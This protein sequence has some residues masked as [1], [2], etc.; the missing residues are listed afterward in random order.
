MTNTPI[1]K[2]AFRTVPREFSGNRAVLKLTGRKTCDVSIVKMEGDKFAINPKEVNCCCQACVDWVKLMTAV[3]NRG[4]KLWKHNNPADVKWLMESARK[5]T[6]MHGPQVECKKRGRPKSN[7][8]F[9]FTLT[10]S[11]ADGLSHTDMVVA[12][13]KVMAQKSQPVKTFAWYL[14]SKG[15]DASGTPIHPHIHGMYETVS[16]V[17]IKDQ[18]WKRAWKLWDP[19]VK[20]GAGFRGGYHR[21]VKSEEAYSEYIAKDGQLGEK[22][23][24]V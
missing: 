23:A 3:N 9:A 12:V 6:D 17:K 13:K 14:E 2:G 24:D 20:L 5:L 1:T 22:S 19:S 8:A 18:H 11:P 4:M 21:P 10:C 15:V 7:G 16:G